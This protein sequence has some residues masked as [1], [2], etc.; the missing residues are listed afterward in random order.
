MTTSNGRQMIVCVCAECG[1][2]KTQFMKSKKTGGGTSK[3]NISCGYNLKGKKPGSMEECFKKG[4]VRYW[5]LKKFD[6]GLLD[7]LIADRNFERN[8]KRRLA[9]K[10]SAVKKTQKKEDISL[11]K[12]PNVEEVYEDPRFNKLVNYFEKNK[13]KRNQR[14]RK[15]NMKI[16]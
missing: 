4:Q 7:A 13:K 2:T 15:M 11:I 16:L 3:D 9:R 1:S 10:K 14:R 5:G 8:E 12:L 6:E